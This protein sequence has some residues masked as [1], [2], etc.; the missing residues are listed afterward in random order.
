MDAHVREVA[1]GRTQNQR[2]RNRR[3]PAVPVNN[4]DLRHGS[5]AHDERHRM[6]AGL[7]RL[8]IHG[9]IVLVLMCGRRM[10]LVCGGA[11]MMLGMIVIAVRVDVQRRRLAGCRG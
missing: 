3:G 6:L 4:M 2:Y 7:A 8:E 9:I 11:M 5:A 1:D 10:M